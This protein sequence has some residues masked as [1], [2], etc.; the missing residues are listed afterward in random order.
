M[1][2]RDSLKTRLAFGIFPR[3][4]EH[5][6]ADFT[7]DYFE[8]LHLVALIIDRLAI[9]PGPVRHHRRLVRKQR[10][11]WV[12][13]YV[14]LRRTPSIAPRLSKDRQ[15]LNGPERVIGALFNSRRTLGFVSRNLKVKGFY[16]DVV[17]V[18]CCDTGT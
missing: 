5:I 18:L 8:T 16:H 9:D 14:R 4:V 10:L 11:Y 17:P 12:E 13:S 15:N 2:H 3:D 6:G 1:T 7:R